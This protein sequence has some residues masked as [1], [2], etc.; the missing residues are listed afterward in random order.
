MACP[1][2]CGLLEFP[3]VARWQ[4][5]GREGASVDGVLMLKH[6][7][8]REIRTAVGGPEGDLAQFALR[9]LYQR[10]AF[11]EVTGV[12]EERFGEEG[13]VRPRPIGPRDK[14]RGPRPRR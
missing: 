3:I 1:H 10:K 6:L 11:R 2:S 13:P 9:I 5:S 12:D 14:H 8:E 4:G 7:A